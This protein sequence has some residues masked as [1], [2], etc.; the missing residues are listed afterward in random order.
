MGCKQVICMLLAVTVVVATVSHAVSSVI[1]ESARVGPPDCGGAAISNNFFVGV[2]FPV[3]QTVEVRSVGGH[4]GGNGFGT[5]F[6]AIVRLDSG[7]AL[8]SGSPFDGTTIAAT[9]FQAPGFATP[10]CGGISEDVKIG[11]IATLEPGWY[12]LI[13]GGGA[14]NISDSPAAIPKQFRATASGFMPSTNTLIGDPSFLIWNNG[15]WVDVGNFNRWRFV[16][17]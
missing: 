17:S 3:L 9:P 8:P 11:L 4:I 13:I 12:G 1:F 2:R 5:F 14:E 10:R 16:V 7:T 6:A 15:S